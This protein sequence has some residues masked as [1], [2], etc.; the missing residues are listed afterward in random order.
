MIIAELTK[1]E[2]KKKVDIDTRPWG[3]AYF[4]D[5]DFDPLPVAEPAK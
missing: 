3:M 4:D 1:K 2:L 5:G